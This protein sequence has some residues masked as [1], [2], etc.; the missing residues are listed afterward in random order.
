NA[1]DTYSFIGIDMCPRPGIGR[2]FNTLG[3]VSEVFI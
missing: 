2:P 1:N 3:Y